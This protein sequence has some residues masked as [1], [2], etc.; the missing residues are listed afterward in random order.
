MN[1]L[2]QVIAALLLGAYALTGTSILPALV[3][4]MARFDG[5]HS[6]SVNFTESGIHLSLSHQNG[7]FT[8]TPADHQNTSGQWVTR[9]CRTTS[10]S[11]HEFNSH[12]FSPRIGSDSDLDL[13]AKPAPTPSLN[14]GASMVLALLAPSRNL[15]SFN[16]CQSFA[17]SRQVPLPS[18]W[19]MTAT[20][21]LLL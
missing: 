18:Q 19:P 15:A 8:P 14:H 12:Q 5:S 7:N 13:T 17:D 9:F 16:P 11:N 1:R 10:S 2:H 21:Q 4:L 3:T 6:V 20:V